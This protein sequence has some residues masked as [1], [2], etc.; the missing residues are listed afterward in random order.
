MY[1]ALFQ[2]KSSRQA[3]NGAYQ[4]GVKGRQY[5]RDRGNTDEANPAKTTVIPW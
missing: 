5:N 4:L 3:L 1:L 2:K